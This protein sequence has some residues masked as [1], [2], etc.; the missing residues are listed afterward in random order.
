MVAVVA[1]FFRMQSNW[2]AAKR[3]RQLNQ[4]AELL[5]QHALLLERFLDDR[6]SPSDLKRLLITVSDT[7]TERDAV[8]R[9]AKWASERPLTEPPSNEDTRATEA[10][11]TALRGHRPDLADDFT[12]ALLTVV[13]GALMS[14]PESAELLEKAFPR[15]LGTPRR[16]VAIAVTATRFRP[17]V[18]FSMKPP[19]AVMA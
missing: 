16:D 17:G 9:F 19:M 13:S 6:A 3:T 8:R 15:L 10:A 12:T 14:W 7:M 1:W 4:A 11:L 2:R 5:D 18:P